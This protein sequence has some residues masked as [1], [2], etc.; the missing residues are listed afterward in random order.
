[1]KKTKILLLT[2]SLMITGLIKAQTYDI[3][4]KGGHV[5]DPKNNIDDVLDIAVKD[6]KIAMIAKN[7]EGKD[8]IQV[9][10]ATGMYVT[11]G[12]IDIHVHV[13][14]GTNL[15]QQYMNGPNAIPPDGFTFR[16]GVTTVVDAGCAGWRTFPEFKKQTID[17]SRTRVLAFLNIVGE[18]MRGGPFEQN[19]K[20]MDPKLTAEFA[21]KNSKDIVGIKLAHYSGRDWTPVMLTEE[22][23]KL[24]DMPIMVDLGG[25]TPPLSLDSLFMQV[26]RPGDIFTHCYAQLGDSRESLVDTKT[27]KV[28]PFAWEA[29]KRGI[30]FDVGYGG[31][32][33]A[34][35]QAIPAL[36]AGFFPDAISTDLHIGS[37]NGAMKDMLT[38]MSKFL[39]MG[40]DLN[41]VINTSTW[42]PAQIINRKELG[43]LS[44]GSDADIAILNIRKGKFGLFDYTGYKIEADK[45]LECEM[46]IRAGKIVYD[47][48]GIANPVTLSGKK[49]A[50]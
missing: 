33:F 17:I 3:V 46:T 38:T 14:N 36:K 35:S 21:L 1:M 34:Y 29:H 4:I 9:V 2:I 16:V 13:F 8:G 26:F 22:A 32:S 50:K 44:V 25:A 18:G 45:K 12:L 39:A 28:W 11:P 24:A 7:V 42:K 47:L 15:D 10:N 41:S 31:I 23:G 43:N 20:D 48:N 40:M 27:G 37:M 6:G 30:I 19:L 49:P 5:I